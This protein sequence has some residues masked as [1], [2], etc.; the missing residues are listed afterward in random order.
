MLMSFKIEIEH[1]KPKRQFHY[2]S[3]G[4]VTA[5]T[6]CRRVGH[7]FLNYTKAAS[8]TVDRLLIKP[9]VRT[10]TIKPPA[11]TN[12]NQNTYPHGNIWA[13]Q[14]TNKPLTVL[15]H[16]LAKL[17]WS[18]QKSLSATQEATHQHNSCLCPKT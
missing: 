4:T 3:D 8:D 11:T 9:A 13:E 14:L 16:C 6:P 12:W 15:T 17:V 18:R 1:P 10:Y 7:F 2:S 5:F